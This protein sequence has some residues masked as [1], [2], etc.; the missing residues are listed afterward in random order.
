MGGVELAGFPFE[1]D[2]DDILEIFL[3][4]KIDLVPL[5]V[6]PC[7]NVPSLALGVNFVQH[8]MFPQESEVLGPKSHPSPVM[9]DKSRIETVDLWRRDDLG[10]PM[11]AEGSD[12]MNDERGLKDCQ[13]VTS[14]RPARFARPRKLSGLKYARALGEQKFAEPAALVGAFGQ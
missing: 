12:H 4:Q 10:R 13:V 5:L 2:G 7:Q 8:I 9:T 3:E 1:L 11:C 6:P 14:S